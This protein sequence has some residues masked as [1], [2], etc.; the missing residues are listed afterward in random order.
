VPGGSRHRK[1]PSVGEPVSDARGRALQGPPLLQEAEVDGVAAARLVPATG[2][3]GPAGAARAGPPRAEDGALLH[4]PPD[5]GEG[6]PADA[7]V[8]PGHAAVVVVVAKV[9][10]ARRALPRDAV[11]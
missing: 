9:V 5:D 11:P 10:E 7:G 4:P 6:L 2:G 1:R 8:V 3:G